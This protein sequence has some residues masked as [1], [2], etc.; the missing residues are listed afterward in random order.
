MIVQRD[1]VR[2]RQEACPV[3]QAHEAVVEPNGRALAAATGLTHNL[4]CLDIEFLQVVNSNRRSER[5][6]H[7]T[8]H[9][10]DVAVLWLG[11]ELGDNPNVVE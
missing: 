3:G 11:D 9:G 5:L 10:D 4:V 7:D 6:V 2:I 1:V 8:E